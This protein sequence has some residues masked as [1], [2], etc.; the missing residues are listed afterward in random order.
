[1]FEAAEDF[2]IR[3]LVGRIN[4]NTEEQ[5]AKGVAFQFENAS[6]SVSYALKLTKLGPLTDFV[7]ATGQLPHSRHLFAGDLTE[8]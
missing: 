4:V 3:F 7:I 2:G 8:P 5:C 6:S 1:V